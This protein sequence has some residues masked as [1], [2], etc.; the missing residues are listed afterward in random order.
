MTK[1]FSL[2]LL[3]FFEILITIGFHIDLEI[4]ACWIIMT[5]ILLF[6][7]VTHLEILKDP[8]DPLIFTFFKSLFIPFAAGGI[9]MFLY[10]VYDYEPAALAKTFLFTGLG[11]VFL[12]AGFISQSKLRSTFPLYIYVT[13]ENK[14]NS[15]LI[16]AIILFILSCIAK[17]YVYFLGITHA[18]NDITSTAIL[19][20]TTQ[21]SFLQIFD[22]IGDYSFV[23]IVFIVF[24]YKRKLLFLLLP[25]C[26]AEIGLA[27]AN[28][29]RL[30]MIL[31]LFYLAIVYHLTIKPISVGRIAIFAGVI[32]LVIIPITTNF[33]NNYQYSLLTNNNQVGYDAI[34]SSFKNGGAGSVTNSEKIQSYQRYY[35]PLEGFTRV[36]QMVPT[37]SDYQLGASFLPGVFIQFIPRFLWPDKP[38]IL[39][40]REFAK[41]F[42]N[43][44]IYEF[45]G[46]NEEIS[47][48]GELYYNFWLFGI[49]LLFFIGRFISFLYSYFLSHRQYEEF[50]ILRYLFLFNNMALL[51]AGGIQTNIA[52]MFKE[53]LILNVFLMILTKSYPKKLYLKKITKV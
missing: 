18:A 47:I 9:L 3:V 28:G 13:K 32:L 30:G 14:I 51:L 24:K 46:T 21:L 52:Q 8:F 45:F 5:T 16:K 39:P 29:G 15:Y 10:P 1:V 34:A 31:P 19:A 20:N 41:T 50:F 40:G 49:V 17:L 22:S 38:I 11:Y 6:P 26:S 27:I 25:L 43:K 48:F 35:S 12:I 44:D 2:V 37:V 4:S 7:F 42:W 53:L 33:R 36:V 23:C